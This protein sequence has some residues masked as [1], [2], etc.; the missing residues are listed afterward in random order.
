MIQLFD[1]R[2][3]KISQLL[4]YL[5]LWNFFLLSII[6]LNFSVFSLNIY[7]KKKININYFL[8]H[9]FYI[10]RIFSSVKWSDSGHFLKS[11][12]KFFLSF[13]CTLSYIYIYKLHNIKSVHVY[14]NYHKSI[15]NC[16]F[17]FT[18]YKNEWREHKFRWQKK[19]KKKHLLQKQ[20]NI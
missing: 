11:Q 3:R 6:L 8:T 13:P 4:L 15:V 20:K 9:P 12:G 5:D 14:P 7:I 16:F 19:V 1:L 10:K 18:I 2:L 17:F